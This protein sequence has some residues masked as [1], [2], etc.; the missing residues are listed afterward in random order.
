MNCTQ[1]RLHIALLSND[2]PEEQIRDLESHLQA[3]PE[4]RRFHQE[5]VQLNSLLSLAETVE[6]EPPAAVWQGI[7][8]R[9]SPAQSQGNWFHQVLQLRELR[10]AAATFAVLLLLSFALLLSIGP[11]AGERLVLAELEGFSMEIRGN[12]FLQEMRQVNPFLL[13]ENPSA[14]EAQVQ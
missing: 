9:I 3:C 2:L 14:V 13:D 6:L 11:S 5:Q 12:P 8:A 10:F 7:K 1:V 4:C